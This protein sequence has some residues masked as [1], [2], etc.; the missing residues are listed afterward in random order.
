MKD[1]ARIN[2]QLHAA[3]IHELEKERDELLYN[4]DVL[5]RLEESKKEV[6]AQIEASKSEGR[7]MV[8]KRGGLKA[9]YDQYLD[10]SAALRSDLRELTQSEKM[11]GLPN[12]IRGWQPSN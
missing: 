11:S 6:I 9:S 4:N 5:A 12:L 2:W 8:E 10:E 3:S 1:Y 7:A